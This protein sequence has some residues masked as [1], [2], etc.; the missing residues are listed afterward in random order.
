M[1]RFYKTTEYTRALMTKNNAAGTPHRV[2]DLR[3]AVYGSNRLSEE[4]VYARAQNTDSEGVNTRYSD[5]F[6]TFATAQ[7][8]ISIRDTEKKDLFMKEQDYP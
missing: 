3:A 4:I 6:G 1:A 2:S 8:A 7:G 5:S